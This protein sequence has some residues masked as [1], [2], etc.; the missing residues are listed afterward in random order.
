[1]ASLYGAFPLEG[2]SQADVRQLGLDDGALADDFLLADSQQQPQQ[3][4]PGLPA[5]APSPAETPFV[6]G[7]S[8]AA[9]GAASAPQLRL[10]VGYAL[11]DCDWNLSPGPRYLAWAQ[12]QR[13]VFT[14]RRVRCRSRVTSRHRLQGAR[15]IR[16]TRHAAHAAAEPLGRPRYHEVLHAK[17]SRHDAGA[18][19]HER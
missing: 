19:G 7:R 1:M 5:G 3:P 9:A 2:F 8:S 10:Q 16:H 6:F 12:D 14:V 11:C 15:S 13:G 17:A 18:C 4:G